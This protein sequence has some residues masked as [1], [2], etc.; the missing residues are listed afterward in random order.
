MWNSIKFLIKC[1]AILKVPPCLLAI[2]QNILFELLTV[3]FL[4]KALRFNFWE[5]QL[6]PKGWGDEQYYVDLQTCENL[7]VD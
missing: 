5:F 2:T 7:H 1:I 3:K 4:R 6:L